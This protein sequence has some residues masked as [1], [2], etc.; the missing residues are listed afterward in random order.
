MISTALLLALVGGCSGDDGNDDGRPVVATTVAPITSIVSAVVGD[1]AEV[2]GIVPEGTSSHTFEPRPSVAALL[3]RAD[4]VFLNGLKLEE[5]T[6][7]LAAA[8]VDDGTAI[9]EL[10]TMVLPE[11]QWLFDVSFPESEGTP[12]PHLW[13]DPTWALRYAEVVRDEMTELDPEGEDVYRRRYDAFAEDVAQLDAALRDAFATIPA[14]DRRLLTY[15]DAY[16][17]FAQTYG[18]DVIGAIQVSDFEDP[19]PRELAGLIDQIDAEG[20][21]AIFG[22]EVLPSPVL[23]QLA[24]ETGARYVDD[25]RDDD[26]PGEP[27]DPEHSLLGLLRFNYALITDALGGDGTAIASLQLATPD[28]TAAYPQ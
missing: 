18:F 11:D 27:G 24:R 14:G 6:R 16:A 9:V 21:S 19:T 26:L 3:S 20:V 5:P 4:I 25:L 12:N 17:Y 23:E 28:D 8:N 7:D 13:T 15:H 2:V 10:G 1:R 22:S